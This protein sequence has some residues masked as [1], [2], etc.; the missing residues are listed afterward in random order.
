MAAMSPAVEPAPCVARSRGAPR[1]RLGRLAG[2]AMLALV[3]TWAPPVR[4]SCQ[5]NTLTPGTFDM[6]MAFGGRTRTFRVH[7]PPS[8]TGR[9]AVPL[10][11]DLHALGETLGL[12]Q[13]LSGF[14]QKSDEAGFIVVWPQGVSA[15]WNGD[16]CCGAALAQNLDDVGFLRALVGLL[17]A[18]GNID[19]SRV[20]ATGHSNGASMAH[21]LACEAADV[22]A[23]VAPVANVL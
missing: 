12:Q 15:S 6:S 20:Y 10:V 16:E 19:H 2:P 14:A 21:R 5:S 9:R 23:A 3:A 13:Y 1:R 8:Y 22:F 17:A 18:V 7:V 11:L 4:A